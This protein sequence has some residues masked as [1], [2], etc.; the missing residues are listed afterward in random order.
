MRT[1]KL[2]A[3]IV[4]LILAAC[5]G[6]Q[7]RAPV[8]ER[9]TAISNKKPVSVKSANKSSDKDWRPDVYVVK[10]GDTLYSVGLEYGYDYKEIAQLNQIE[11]PY[12]IRV[13]QSLKLKDNKVQAKNPAPQQKAQ[14]DDVIIKPLNTQNSMSKKSR[15]LARQPKRQTFKILLLVITKKSLNGRGQPKGKSPMV[16]LRV[17]ALKGLILKVL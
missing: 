8:I 12:V 6:T 10:K 9:S 2:T 16:L 17:A 14:E 15:L 13:G 5:S 11:Q 4:C 7:N 3:S 1:K